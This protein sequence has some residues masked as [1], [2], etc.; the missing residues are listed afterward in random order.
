MEPPVKPSVKPSLVV[1]AAGIGSRY[2]GLKQ[3]EPVGPNGETIIDYSVYDAVRAGFGK[4]VFVIRRDIDAA[5]REAFGGRFEERTPVEY[6]YQELDAGLPSGFAPPVGRKKPWGTAHAILLTRDVVHEPFAAI[7]ADD[8]YGAGSF[9]L[10][11]EHLDTAGDGEAASYAMVGFVLRNTLSEFGSV[12]RGVCGC[13]ERS[14][15]RKVVEITH[16]D[17]TGNGARY[18]DDSGQLKS[19]S[20]DEVV[21]M[22]MWGFTPSIFRH[23]EPRFGEFLRTQAANPK[24]ELY[25]PTIVNALLA[26][27]RAQVKV[28]RT[29]DAWFGVTYPEDRPQ[30][31]QGIRRLIAAGEYPE[32]LWSA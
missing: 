17:K 6:V 20:G 26:E 13:D 14:F 23:L 4:L 22:N 3:I 28:L 7:N 27:G 15:L 12:S 8:F 5:F 2:G 10:L 29:R 19:L 25:L 30:V 32:R 16:I 9:Q 1:L 31:M 18:T 24:S 11:K 21:S